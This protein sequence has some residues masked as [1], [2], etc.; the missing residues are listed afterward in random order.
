MPERAMVVG[1]AGR[2]ESADDRTLAKA[3]GHDVSHEAVSS[4]A[5]RTAPQGRP[6]VLPADSGAREYRAPASRGTPPG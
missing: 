6:A 5:P 2:R 3:P 4:S 1:S